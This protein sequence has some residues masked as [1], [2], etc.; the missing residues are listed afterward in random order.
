MYLYAYYIK[1]LKNNNKSARRFYTYNN[2]DTFIAETVNNIFNLCRRRN[3]WIPKCLVFHRLNGRASRL[4]QFFMASSFLEATLDNF[5]LM[6][7]LRLKNSS[8]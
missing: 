5:I 4:W 6:C 3:V 7:I 1:L 8:V 2:R